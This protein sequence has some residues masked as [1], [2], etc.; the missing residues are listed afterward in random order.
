MWEGI[1]YELDISMPEGRRVTKLE[2]NGVPLDPEASFDVVMNSYRSGGGGNF[3]M[4]KDKPIIREIP[5][6]MTE[7]LAD[8]IMKRRVI[9]ARNNFV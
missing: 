8:Y 2:Q 3:D 9:H 7:I 4:I 1:E 6:D 5:T